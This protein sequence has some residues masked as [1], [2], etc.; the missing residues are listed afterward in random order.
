VLAAGMVGRNSL[1]LRFRETSGR[2]GGT[3]T[4]DT[5]AA[6]ARVGRLVVVVASPGRRTADGHREVA[7]NLIR[8]AV[9]RASILL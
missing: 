8:P 3:M 1:L 6:V 5:Y 2:A 7:E 9:R 4:R